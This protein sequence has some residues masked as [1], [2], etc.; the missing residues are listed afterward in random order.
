MA[1][2]RTGK[3][4]GLHSYHQTTNGIVHGPLSISCLPVKSSQIY[5]L[6]NLLVRVP[7][8]FKICFSLLRK[9]ER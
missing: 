7:I 1:E 5:V 3:D 4:V 6:L 8:I 9:I 2:V